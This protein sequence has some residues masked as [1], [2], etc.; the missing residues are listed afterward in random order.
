MDSVYP[1]RLA[2]LGPIRLKNSGKVR[3]I[4]EVDDDHLLF[5]TSDRVSAFDVIMPQ[6]I[7]HKGRVLTA[8]AAHWF[9]RTQDLI[10]NHLVS[11]RVED[12]PGLPRAHHGALRGRIMYVKRCVPTSVEWVVRGYICGSG[13]K[14]YQKKGS[15]CDVALPEGLA[16][17]ERFPEPIFTPTTKDDTHDLPITAAE[18]RDRVGPAVYAKAH[19]AAL[20]LFE[21]G[22]AELAEIGILLA[23]T[24]FEFGVRDGEVLLIDEALTPDSSRFWPKSEYATGQNQPSYDKQILRDWLETLDW[25]KNP[26]APDVPPEIVN[27]VAERYLEICEKITGSAPAGLP[28]K[29]TA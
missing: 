26:P 11:T 14:E 22:T 29:G 5:V 10:A 2:S 12:V 24:K 28:T 1:G 27:R 17:C 16:F 4:Y 7:P 6:G 20:A 23:D 8:I 3:D 19:A 21:R 13:W 25:D 15:I 18:A 9:A